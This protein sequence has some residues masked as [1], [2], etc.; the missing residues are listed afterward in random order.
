MP[1]AD[2]AT[3]IGLPVLVLAVLLAHGWLLQAVSGTLAHSAAMAPSDPPPAQARWITLAQPSPPAA[4]PAPPAATPAAAATARPTAA[5]P[6]R[7]PPTPTEAAAPPALDTPAPTATTPEPAAPAEPVASADPTASTVAQTEPTPNPAPA[8]PQVTL[9][10]DARLQYQV[11]G[12]AR[13]LRYRAA[14][15]LRWQRSGDRYDLSMTLSAFLIGSRSQ[16]STGQTDD[17]GLLPERFSDR[18]RS[19][20]ATHFDRATG[21]I[22]FSNNAPEAA[23]LPGAQDRLSVFLQLG[24]LLQSGA[25]ASGDVIALPVAGV[26]GSETWKFVVGETETLELP[27]GPM[28]ARRLLREPA[29]T[30]DSRVELWLAPE[31]GHLPVRLRISQKSGDVADQ[32]LSQRP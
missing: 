12:Q 27:A 25:Y 18:T 8:L 22:R 16:T 15:E 3:R 6:V 26:G 24:G 14:G 5:Q 29:D 19:E 31:L 10:P 17:T 1:K 28:A 32:Q 11:Q 20:R 2:G 21:R 13:G 7:R 4:A 30:Y 23:L 9:P